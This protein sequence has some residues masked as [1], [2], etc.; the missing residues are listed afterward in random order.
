MVV[1]LKHST[2][3]IVLTYWK[4]L[5]YGS[6]ITILNVPRSQP[7]EVSGEPQRLKCNSGL[8]T[9]DR[10]LTKGKGK[11]THVVQFSAPQLNSEIVWL[12]LTS[13]NIPHFLLH[14]RP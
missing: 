5:S 14:C 6:H 12:K 3:I 1:S 10:N 11:V 9:A 2:P 13:I 7:S 4:T 8:L